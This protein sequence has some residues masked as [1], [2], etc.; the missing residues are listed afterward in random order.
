MAI[1]VKLQNGTVSVGGEFKTALAFVKS[2]PGRRFDGATKTWTVAMGLEDFGKRCRLPYDILAGQNSQARLQSGN[3][4]TRY[5]TAYTRSEWDANK[6]VWVA[7]RK[8]SA[9]FGDKFSALKREL[10]DR[11]EGIGLSDRAVD[12][13]M[14]RENIFSIE[15]LEERGAVKFSSEE[16]RAAVLAVAKWY[17][18]EF[19]KLGDAERDAIETEQERIFA[20]Y[21]GE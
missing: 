3:H 2:L 8:I 10:R 1:T 20:R 17:G 18:D 6:A 9:E 16:R 7:E 11:L 12:F 19:V 15:E 5:G 4:V 13:L 21:L 14:A